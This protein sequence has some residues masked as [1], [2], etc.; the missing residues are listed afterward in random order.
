MLVPCRL[1][2][3]YQK[4][5]L[6]FLE[7]LELTSYTY[8]PPGYMG[9]SLTQ[10]SRFMTHETIHHHWSFSR[11]NTSDPSVTTQRDPVAWRSITPPIYPGGLYMINI[12]QIS[13][14]SYI[15]NMAET[16]LCVFAQ[17]WNNLWKIIKCAGIHNKVL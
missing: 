14:Y 10:L 9:A 16:V 4:Y 3:D 5:C 1:Y 13:W 11:L 8:S 2:V 12:D 6:H 7:L 15:T 17:L